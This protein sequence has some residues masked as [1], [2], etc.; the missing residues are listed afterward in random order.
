MATPLPPDSSARQLADAIHAAAD[1]ILQ[2][3]A[4]LLND[5]PDDELFGDNEFVVR[6]R[7]LRI[8]G[9]AYQARLAQKKM[10]TSV[11]ASTAPTAAKPPASTATAAGSR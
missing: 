11:P 3:V 9:A 4:Q 10:A 8:V 5:L 6:D 7:I 2:E 1:D